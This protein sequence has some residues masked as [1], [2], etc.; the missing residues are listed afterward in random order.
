MLR[1]ENLTCAYGSKLILQDLTLTMEAGSF[2]AILG[3][4]G[5]GKSTLL[6]NLNG[7]LQPQ[8]GTVLV[9]GRE[10]SRMGGNEAARLIGYMPQ[11]SSASACTVFDAVLLG[12]KPH[13]RWNVGERDLQV[14]DR[15]LTLLG[16]QSYALRR[17]SE[18]SGGE[19]QKVVIARALAQEPKVLLLDEPISHLD[20]R[21]QMDTLALLKKIVEELQLTVAVVIHDLSMALRFADRFV[22]LKQGS[23]YAAGDHGVIT[24]RSIR[25]VFHIDAAIHRIDGVPVVVPVRDDGQSS[26]PK[27]TQSAHDSLPKR[28]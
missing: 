8:S 9:D 25:D 22:L 2:T 13:I 24:R 26:G 28:T 23:L 18:L 12:R 21:N 1:T 20:I 6:Q 5:S 17:T 15:T 7:I 3:I 10:L 11:K 16:L 4:N 27:P 19:L 14:V